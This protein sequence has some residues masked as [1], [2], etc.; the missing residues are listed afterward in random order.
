[1]EDVQLTHLSTVL[2]RTDGAV[3]ILTRRGRV[4]KKKSR[5][6]MDRDP[7]PCARYGS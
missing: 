1:L 6:A 7:S 4:I 3:E 2:V 5:M